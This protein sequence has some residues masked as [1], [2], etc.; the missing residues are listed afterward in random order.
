MQNGKILDIAH[1]SFLDMIKI[2]IDTI[3][4]AGARGTLIRNAI[5]AADCIE[6]VEYASLEEFVNAI[7]D[8]TNPITRI[9]G[10]AV[11][12]GENVFGLPACP[13][14]AS[15]KNYTDMFSKLPDGYAELTEDS[16]KPNN[17]AEKLKVAHGA[18]VSP[19]CSVH[20]PMRSAFGEKIKIGGKKV[21]IYMLGCKSGGGK[22]AIADKWIADTGISKETVEKVLDSNMCCYYL[23][24]Q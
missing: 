7:A 15:I 2:M 17:I 13:F 14:A 16:N 6:E 3:G 11:Y 9:E 5:K 19:F 20:Q 23:M 8:G 10:K 21:T 4:N 18:C 12:V 1:I 22:K 24:M